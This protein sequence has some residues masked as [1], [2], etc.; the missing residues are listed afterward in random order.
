MGRGIKKANFWLR[1]RSHLPLIAICTLVIMVLVF[2]EDTSI[3]LNMQYDREIN[4]LTQA[5]EECRD[6]ASY[7]RNRREELVHGT[8][9]LEQIAREQ[10]HMQR[11]TE[12]VFILK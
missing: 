11:P 9:N 4:E 12:D 6:S 1:R 2:N 7:Y 5:I 3:T 10:F 8:G